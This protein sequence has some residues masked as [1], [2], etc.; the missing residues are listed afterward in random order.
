MTVRCLTVHA[1]YAC[2][3]S[4]A[5]CTAGWPIPV[6]ADRL[7]T[8]A[9]AID[10]GRLAT[11]SLSRPLWIQPADA[12]AATPALLQSNDHGCVFYEAVPASVSEPARTERGI[13]A[14]ASERE[15]GSGGA[16]PLERGRCRV[17]RTLGHGALP[18]AC[19]QFP[20]IS[21]LDPRGASVTLSHYCP[22]AAGLLDVGEVAI[23]D[24]PQAFPPDAELVGLDVRTNLPPL[25]RPGML[26]DW[27][28]WWDWEQR[29]VG[30]IARPD[31]SPEQALAILSASVESVRT[32]RPEDGALLAAIHDG[33]ERA[34]GRVEAGP[35][36]TL[37]HARGALSLS[38]GRP[39]LSDVLSA[40]PADLCPSRL[41]RLDAPS[42][43]AVRA[44]LAAHAFANW[45]AHLGQGLR[46]WLR[47]L[48]AALSLVN[49][50]GVRQTDLILRHL[51]DPNELVNGW[52][53]AEWE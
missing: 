33:F 10:D 42:A 39:A 3:H 20:R 47:S 27:E 52:S 30:T 29:A 13:R 21:V 37:R 28:S 31:R 32:W 11:P 48:Q 8:L 6:E 9:A 36:F 51:A 1:G 35:A 17:H 44:F 5:C 46:S 12:P 25:L 38:K 53:R 16:K 7:T 23:T 49:E 26:M 22:T 14:P 41:E 4:G 15:G 40:I 50:L 34:D 18:L 24:E 2:R 19:R 43:T 45:T